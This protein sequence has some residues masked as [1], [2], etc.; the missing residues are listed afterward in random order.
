MLSTEKCEKCVILLI[1]EVLYTSKKTWYLIKPKVP[2]LGFTSLHV[3][4]IYSK[5]MGL[6]QF[7]AGEETKELHVATY[8]GLR[9]FN[10]LCFPYA[11]FTAV[12]VLI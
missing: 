6:Q 7:I 10:R 9:S 2:R 8:N 4:D 3:C 5:F 12:C 1:D 11:Q